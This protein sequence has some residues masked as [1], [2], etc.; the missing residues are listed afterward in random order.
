MLG[1]EIKANLSSDK[2]SLDMSNL[3]NGNYLVKVA[4]ESGFKN[5]FIIF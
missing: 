2:T 3:A 4:I 1:Q 5:L